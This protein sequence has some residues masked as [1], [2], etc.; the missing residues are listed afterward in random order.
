[1]TEVGHLL[2]GAHVVDDDD[3]RVIQQALGPGLL[4]EAAEPLRLAGHA[5]WQH[6]DRDVPA[7]ARVLGTVDLPHAAGAQEARDLVGSEPGT[8]RDWHG[9]WLARII[10]PWSIQALRPPGVRGRGAREA[11]RVDQRLGWGEG[12]RRGH[13]QHERAEALPPAREDRSLDR[14]NF[15]R[16]P[17]VD[18]RRFRERHLDAAGVAPQTGAQHL[19][20]RFLAAP[21]EVGEEVACV[22]AARRGDDCA[23][24][25]AQRQFFASIGETGN[26]KFASVLNLR[27]AT[28]HRPSASDKLETLFV[29]GE[30]D[31]GV[32]VTSI[33]KDCAATRIW[34]VSNRNGSFQELENRNYRNNRTVPLWEFAF[35]PD[36]FRQDVPYLGSGG[37]TYEPEP[38]GE[39]VTHSGTEYDVFT[40]NGNER[41]LRPKR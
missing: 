28:S 7:Q 6:L 34:P 36:E 22:P 19:E 3:V 40:R 4:L 5:R 21:D 39:V 33:N 16:R 2:V 29:L 37:T 20:R 32:F 18:A 11:G 17:A 15:H 9:R 8:L 30:I 23:V 35:E 14:A 31:Y 27:Q 24:P 13:R 26:V 25:E 10:E 1:M 41:I 12:L 38:T